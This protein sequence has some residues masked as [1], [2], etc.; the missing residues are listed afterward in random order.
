[1]SA[2]DFARLK[3]TIYYLLSLLVIILVFTLL[4][5]QAKESAFI[6]V[7]TTVDQIVEEQRMVEQFQHSFDE[8]NRNFQRRLLVADSI[9]ILVATIFSWWM[10]GR[11]LAPIQDMLKQQKDFAADVSHELKTPL[12]NISLEIQTARKLER[13]PR[14][15]MKLLTSIEEEVS[16]MTHMVQG[17]LL[18]VRSQHSGL[19]QELVPT[20]LKPLL[21]K[22]A[23]AMKPLA[24]RKGIAIETQIH[25]SVKVL[26]DAAQ[27]YQV[28]LI[29]TDNAIKYS[30]QKTTITIRL[31][32]DNSGAIIE[33]IDEGY[34]IPENEQEAIF[35]RFYRAHSLG[36]TKAKGSGLGLAI[37]HRIVTLHAGTIRL[38]SQL[39][40]GTTFTIRL[41]LHETS[42]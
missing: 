23:L 35:D 24:D 29:L 10:S 26:A 5:F 16:R 2:F 32:T 13:L 31:I 17:L 40:E 6:R 33:V 15:A 9:L 39:G 34:G 1:M 30:P 11:T 22:S 18:L 41:P 14:S 27:L 19:L 3:L 4:T 28:L 37:A 7:R 38:N 8:T 36:D 42:G 21:K 20:D 12:A 25:Q